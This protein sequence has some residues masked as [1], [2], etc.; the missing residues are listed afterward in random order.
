[1]FRKHYMMILSDDEKVDIIT[2][3]AANHKLQCLYKIGVYGKERQHEL[4]LIGKPW[5]YHEF[6]KELEPNKKK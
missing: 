4:Y 6:M 2:K 5:N 3:I 1:M